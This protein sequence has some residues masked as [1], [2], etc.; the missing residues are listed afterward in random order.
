MIFKNIFHLIKS[1]CFILLIAS[2]SDNSQAPQIVDTSSVP[3][4]RNAL[5]PL[6]PQEEDHEITVRPETAI[7]K[8]VQ[9]KSS[10]GKNTISWIAPY[11]RENG[12]E[13]KPSDLKKYI[14]YYGIRS[15]TYTDNIEIN[16]NIYNHLPTSVSVDHLEP[17]IVYYFSGI[18]V[19]SNGLRSV[20]SN[21]ISRLIQPWTPKVFFIQEL[22]KGVPSHKV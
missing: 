7:S 21:E 20:M 9:T 16:K 1:S 17:G 5:L 14:I 11:K 6:V 2:C 12:T 18:S 19:D 13:V 8:T 22:S 15:E 4:G 3:S 10:L